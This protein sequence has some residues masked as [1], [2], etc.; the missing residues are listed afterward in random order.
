MPVSGQQERSGRQ[1]HVRNSLSTPR[2][3][4]TWGSAPHPGSVACGGSDAPRRSLAC[5]VRAALCTN[6]NRILVRSRI[7]V[8]T[9][10]CPDLFGFLRPVS[11][12]SRSAECR[13]TETELSN[14]PQTSVGYPTDSPT[15]RC[16]H[17]CNIVFTFPRSRVYALGRARQA[18][19]GTIGG[20]GRA[21]VPLAQ[22]PCGAC[23]VGVARVSSVSDHGGQHVWI[24]RCADC[25][26]YENHVVVAG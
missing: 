23:I 18:R 12:P 19:Q 14:M 1:P 5:A 21:I 24:Y 26:K 11:P 4:L 6:E 2:N 15:C 17:Y 25:G 13:C 10:H 20:G 16:L 7:T 3:E 22:I 9:C 8:K